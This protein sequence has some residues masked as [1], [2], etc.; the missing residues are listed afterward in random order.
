MMTKNQQIKRGELEKSRILVRTFFFQPNLQIKVLI[1]CSLLYLKC[2]LDGSFAIKHLF[3]L[4]GLLFH[5]FLA[6]V[7]A[8]RLFQIF[9]GNRNFMY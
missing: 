9:Q 4:I 2:S 6:S 8:L 7:S 3:Y 1:L 5:R